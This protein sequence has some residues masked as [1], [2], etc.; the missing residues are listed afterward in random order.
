MPKK[1]ARRQKGY[2][3]KAGNFWY[4][5]K[6]EKIHIYGLGWVNARAAFFVGI[7]VMIACVVF[8]VLT[9]F[10]HLH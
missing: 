1:I 8:I 3:Y 5:L 7:P 4:P 2:T 10:S 6:G 9:V